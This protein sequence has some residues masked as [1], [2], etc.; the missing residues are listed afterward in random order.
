MHDRQRVIMNKTFLLF[1]KMIF[2][3]RQKMDSQ[4]IQGK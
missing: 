3:I 2:L 1:M 4:A